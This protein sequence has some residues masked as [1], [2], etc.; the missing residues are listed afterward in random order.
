ML[1][2]SQVCWNDA[3]MRGSHATRVGHL[4]CGLSSFSVWSLRSFTSVQLLS[5]LGIGFL[6][7]LYALDA[8][9]G[10]SEDPSIV[11]PT[12]LL[13]SLCLISVRSSMSLFKAY[14]SQTGYLFS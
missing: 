14:F 13:L 4:L 1:I 6:Q 12:F 10:L 9:D 5:V 2:I 3:N 8:A 7:G 11:C